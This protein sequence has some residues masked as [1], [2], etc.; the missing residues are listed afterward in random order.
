MWFIESFG[1]SLRIL[2]YKTLRN[3]LTRYDL[4]HNTTGVLIIK[5]PP[6][7][8]FWP[9]DFSRG[10]Y[11]SSKILAKFSLAFIILKKFPPAA[12]SYYYI[13]LRRPNLGSPEVDFLT[14]SAFLP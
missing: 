3:Y 5:P 12:G 13:F 4:N 11:Y 1:K 9:P 10:F 8:D 2:N 7:K 14:R 6:L